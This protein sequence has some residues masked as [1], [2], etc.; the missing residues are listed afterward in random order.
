L[1]LGPGCGFPVPQIGEVGL[2]FQ[3]KRGGDVVPLHYYAVGS[4]HLKSTIKRIRRSV[5]K[6]K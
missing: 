6:S 1:E 5:Q 3:E 4:E 2:F